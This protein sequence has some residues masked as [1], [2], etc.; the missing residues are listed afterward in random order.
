MGSFNFR[1]LQ[2]AANAYHF[3]ASAS[4]RKRMQRVSPYLENM[5]SFIA[6]RYS[7]LSFARYG[8][9][10]KAYLFFV[11]WGHSLRV[12]SLSKHAMTKVLFFRLTSLSFFCMIW[13][14]GMPRAVVAASEKMLFPV[15]MTYSF[16]TPPIVCVM[17]SHT[18]KN[19]K[20]ASAAQAA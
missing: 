18:A 13:C 7:R 16:K 10:K 8:K 2:K 1:A 20:A 11:F 19:C 17:C 9:S 3:E 12:R 15:L 6:P 4:L 14:S 5:F